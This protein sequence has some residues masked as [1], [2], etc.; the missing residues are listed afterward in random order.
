MTQ[1]E[2]DLAS[3]LALAI[4]VMRDHDIDESMAGEFTLFTDL[5]D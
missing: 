5:I 3:A 1:R 4:Q 2:I